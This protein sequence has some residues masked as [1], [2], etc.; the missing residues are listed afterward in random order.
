MSQI[1]KSHWLKAYGYSL[2][3]HASIVGVFA[4]LA[5]WHGGLAAGSG[6]LSVQIGGQEGG[7]TG[8]IGVVLEEGNVGNFGENGDGRIRTSLDPDP[9]AQSTANLSEAAFSE[10]EEVREKLKREKDRK[11]REKEREQESIDRGVDGGDLDVPVR[12]EKLEKPQEKKPE[13][14]KPE[15]KRKSTSKGK[16]GENQ[17]N[18]RAG[19]MG[20][21]G[22]AGTVTGK[23]DAAG[24][25]VGTTLGEGAGE[26]KF[27][28]N[29]DGTFTATGSAGLAFTIIHDAQVRYPR[30]ARSIGYGKKVR[31]TV[32]FL[33]G[34]DGLVKN[35]AVINKNLPDLGF[36]EEALRAV[37]QMQFEPI[38]HQGKT[39][40]VYFSKN[41]VFV[42]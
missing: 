35:A 16:S 6:R 23:K 12:K 28:D 20:A 36:K 19:G 32:K 1:F 40:S 38:V 3:L 26:G 29:G 31:V 24:S 10:G 25:G 9:M 41:I 42:P 30:A 13:P 15:P 7:Q 18:A 33:V 21:A 27:R 5:L 22:A 8:G 34:E 11:K 14:V 37:R 39:I 4:L 2:G 17:V